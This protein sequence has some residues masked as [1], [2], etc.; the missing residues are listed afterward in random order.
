MPR[1][2]ATM[3][4]RCRC[5]RRRSAPAV[6]RRA[7]PD[8]GPASC[9]AAGLSWPRRR[10]VRRECAPVSVRSEHDAYT[11]F[12]LTCNKR[13][14]GRGNLGRI[15][16]KSSEESDHAGKQPEPG[17][18]AVE[19][20]RAKRFRRRSRPDREERRRA[21]LRATSTGNDEP[22][23]RTRN[24]VRLRDFERVADPFAVSAGHRSIGRQEDDRLAPRS[25]LLGE[26]GRLPASGIPM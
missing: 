20:E 24:F 19:A 13:G 17:S 26:T 6:P 5:F 18:E 4:A 7:S 3:R 11:D 22:A 2:S 8:D 10:S 25:P 16:A 23:G 21:P 9:S 15:R 14:D 12:V 1:R